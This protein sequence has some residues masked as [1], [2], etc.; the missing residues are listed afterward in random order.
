MATVSQKSW[1]MNI[2]YTDEHHILYWKLWGFTFLID[3]KA[4]VSVLF[5]L[6]KARSEVTKS[7]LH[8]NTFD[9]Y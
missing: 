3:I 9:T 4:A 8:M 7:Y 1:A 5:K 2:E 6:G